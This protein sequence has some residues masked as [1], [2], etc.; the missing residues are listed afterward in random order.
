MQFGRFLTDP[1]SGQQCRIDGCIPST[2]LPQ[3][4]KLQQD[5]SNIMCCSSAELPPKI[6]LRPNMTPVENQATIGSW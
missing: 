1:H 5:F 6:D 2:H 3:K 4:Y